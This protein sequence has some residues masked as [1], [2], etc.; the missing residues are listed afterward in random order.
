MMYELLVVVW[1]TVCR[2]PL[3]VCTYLVGRNLLLG[4]EIW[5]R[6]IGSFW[7]SKLVPARLSVLFQCIADH[8]LP[9]IDRT[10]TAMM[11]M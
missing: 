6:Q 4:K 10:W 2:F 7:N 11:L 1:S 5:N 8:S 3:S 9:T